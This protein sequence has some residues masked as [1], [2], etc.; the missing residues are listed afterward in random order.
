MNKKKLKIII[1]LSL[2]VLLIFGVSALARYHQDCKQELREVDR[3]AQPYI[4]DVM[5]ALGAWNYEA[6]EPF[7]TQNYRTHSSQEEW[8]NELQKFSGLGGLQSFARPR[9]VSHTPFKRFWML[10]SAIDFYAISAEFENANAVVRLSFENNCGNLK[11]DSIKITSPYFR[12]QLDD[13]NDDE[14]ENSEAEFEEIDV[15]NYEPEDLDRDPEDEII[16]PDFQ[17]EIKKKTE[18]TRWPRKY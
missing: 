3:Y 4:V 16:S 2:V 12:Y 5:E 10:E 17:P 13:S 18:N 11:V 7:L 14:L 9:F 8:K 6:I 15:L 1:I